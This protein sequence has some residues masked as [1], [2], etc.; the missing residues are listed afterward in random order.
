MHKAKYNPDLA[1]FFE[2]SRKDGVGRVAEWAY[3][4]IVNRPLIKRRV[5]PY[6]R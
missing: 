6:I 1:I 3:S 2:V 5:V 4:N